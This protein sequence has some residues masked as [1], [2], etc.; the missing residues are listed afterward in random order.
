MCLVAQ[1]YG[2]DAWWLKWTGSDLV[3]LLELAQRTHGDRGSHLQQSLRDAVRAGRLCAE[4][5]LPGS[6][7]LA[8]A[9]RMARGTVVEAYEQ[10]VA[11]GYLEAR[12]GSGTLV[13]SA[14]LRGA[15]EPPGTPPG[16]RRFEVDLRPG[17]PDL[18]SFP[19]DDWAW[20]LA[21][22][23]RSIT[24]GQL[25]YGSP[26]GHPFAREAIAGAL[27]RTRAAE[28]TPAAVAL[29]SGFAQ[30]VTLVLAVLAERGVRSLAVEDPGDRS[31]D[32]VAHSVGMEV[33]GIPVDGEGI[34]V[35]ALAESGAEAVIVTPAHQAPTGAVLSPS[36]RAQLIAW[37]DATG[38]WVLEDDYDSEFRYDRQPVGALQGVAPDRV[39]LFGSTSKTHAPAIRIGWI[40]APGVLL[41]RLA[42]RKD[43]ADRGSSAL[44]QF[45]FGLLLDSGRHD[46]HVRAMRSVYKRRRGALVAALGEWAP[47][48][49]LTGIEAGFHGLLQLPSGSAEDDVVERAAERSVALRG[50]TGYSLLQSGL[51]T[52][53]LGFGGSDEEQIEA[54]VRIIADLTR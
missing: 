7:E 41:P 15:A 45:A 5:R 3:L 46:R 32:D 40:A 35:E 39:I 42:E 22:A 27:R 43:A 33:I 38:G 50:L 49:R 28:T 36:R 2:P 17:F 21:R 14:A 12:S 26:L 10:L 13:A 44:D 29:G 53:A 24:R 25:T 30:C 52:L 23:A 9:A 1:W 6:R 47:W 54:G 51:P 11:E 37:A 48:L 4:E 20:A 19:G 8:V 16:P 31:V 18:G 34:D